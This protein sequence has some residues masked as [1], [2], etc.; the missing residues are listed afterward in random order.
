MS[1]LQKSLKFSTQLSKYSKTHYH[2]VYGAFGGRI[3]H[4]MNNIFAL[5]NSTEQIILVNKYSKM[6]VLHPLNLEE[7]MTS[8]DG[9]NPD[10]YLCNVN[11]QDKFDSEYII[12]FS[13]EIDLK[14]GVGLVPLPTSNIALKKQQNN[15]EII[16][17]GLKW[18]IGGDLNCL[19]W[20]SMISTSNEIVGC[21]DD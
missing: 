14:K 20:D 15:G 6:I 19:S 11:N 17:K 8:S 18:N 10:D 12:K 13:E 16:T 7:I 21:P 4:T 3:D 9:A 1:D 2:I 5:R